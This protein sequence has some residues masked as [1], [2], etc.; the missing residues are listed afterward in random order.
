MSGTLKNPCKD[1]ITLGRCRHKNW[2]PLL[3]HCAILRHYLANSYREAHKRGTD[4][5]SFVFGVSNLRMA[6]KVSVTGDNKIMIG[7]GV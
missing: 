6:F 7:P 4:R 5:H 1:C 3:K 2:Y